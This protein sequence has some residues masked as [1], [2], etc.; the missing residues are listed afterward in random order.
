VLCCEQTR[1]FDTPVREGAKVVFSDLLTEKGKALEE[2]LGKS[3]RILSGGRYKPIRNR[4]TYEIHHR[5]FR[6]TRLCRQ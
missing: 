1:P 5:S 2:E 6:E 4:G 3:A